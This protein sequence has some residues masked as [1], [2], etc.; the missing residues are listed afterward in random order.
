LRS[1]HEFS[2]PKWLFFTAPLSV[3]VWAWLAVFSWQRFRS[4]NVV[5]KGRAYDL[6][7]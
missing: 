1:D 4:G 3:L 5:W 2:F 7:K 6:R